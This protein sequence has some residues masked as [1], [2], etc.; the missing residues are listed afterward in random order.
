MKPCHVMLAVTLAATVTPTAQA[1]A[2]DKPYLF[3]VMVKG[4]W[5]I[6]NHSGKVIIPPVHDSVTI[7]DGGFITTEI[8]S[9]QAYWDASG[10]PIFTGYRSVA[11][12]DKN[13]LHRF[14]SSNF[15]Y[16]LLD[17]SGQ[18]K[19]P[20]IYASIKPF[21]DQKNYVARCRGREGVIG[22]DG[23]QVIPHTFYG[24]QSLSDGGLAIA[25]DKRGSVG[26]VDVSGQWT[27]RPG[28][29]DEIW[30]F[31]QQLAA[32]KKSGKWGVV[33]GN[34]E[35][36]IEPI[37][38]DFDYWINFESHGATPA[39]LG[40]KW[41]LIDRTGKRTS[42]A[43]FDT[44]VATQDGLFR[45]TV[46]GKEG[47]V[48]KYGQYVVKAVFDRIGFFGKEGIANAWIGD[49]KLFIDRTGKEVLSG[50]F[51]S[52]G[53]FENGW[54]AAKTKGKWGAINTLGKWILKPIYQCVGTCFDDDRPF[55]PSTNNMLTPERTDECDF[56]KMGSK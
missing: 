31:E 26:A 6:V 50:R 28:I 40:E 32:A 10:K 33:N 27:L 18:I 37:Y 1:S 29:V 35:W 53:Y 23:R 44:L 52:I 16:G 34:G 24:L 51:Q 48:D 17:R 2:N 43:Q 45:V 39:K 7:S 41:F 49:R 14:R 5:G 56:A 25:S 3:E 22:L 9:K 30:E 36:V 42:N 46:D 11:P 54:A 20:A 8:E 15:L 55:S 21:D 19:L 4:K 47:V 38:D 12:A 13:G